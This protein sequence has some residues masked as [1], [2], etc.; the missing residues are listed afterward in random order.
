VDTKIALFLVAVEV[1][2][3]GELVERVILSGRA[4]PPL[5]CNEHA[6]EALGT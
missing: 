5:K 6:A 3:S 4:I 1:R 2:R